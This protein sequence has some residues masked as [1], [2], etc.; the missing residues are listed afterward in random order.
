ME[1]LSVYRAYL[2]DDLSEHELAH[3]SGLAIESMFVQVKRG[4]LIEELLSLGWLVPSSDGSVL[5]VSQGAEDAFRGWARSGGALYPWEGRL[6]RGGRRRRRVTKGLLKEWETS[7][8][9]RAGLAAVVKI[10]PSRPETRG[11][12]T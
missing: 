7:G 12:Q 8:Y 3:D 2:G 9:V 4:H 1:D 5:E 11:G 10:H 6:S